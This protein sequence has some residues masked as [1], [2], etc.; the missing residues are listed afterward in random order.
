MRASVL[1]RFS[2]IRMTDG[3]E[4][5]YRSMV[6]PGSS[7]IVDDDPS[8]RITPLSAARSAGAARADLEATGSTR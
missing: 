6:A 2:A 5:L 8:G 3:Y 7:G 1:D 4:A